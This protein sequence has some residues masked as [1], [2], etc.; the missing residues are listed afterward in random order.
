MRLTPLTVCLL[1]VAPVAGAAE[2][3]FLRDGDRVVFYGDSITD[4][5]WY[6]TLVQTFVLTRHPAW[7]NQFS[8]RGQSGDNAG[9]LKRFERDA[10]VSKPDVVIFAMGY[11]DGGYA[12]FTGASLEKFLSNV[13]ASVRRVR[14]AGPAV[15]I[16]LVSPTP[17]ELAVSSD[18]RWVSREW[19][20][21]HLLM[22]SQGE[23][24]LAARLGVGFTDMTERYGQTLG[25]GRVV[26]GDAFALSRDGVHPQQEGQ[27][28]IA[29]HLLRGLGTDGRLAETVINGAAGTVTQTGRC[30]VSNLSLAD[31]ALTFT[32]TCESLPYPTPEVAR[33][34]R[35]LVQLDDTLNDDRLVVTGLTAPS[36]ALAI[37]GQP[38]AEVAAAALA[39]GINLSQYAGTPMYRQAMEV[40]DAVRAK[41]LLDCGFWR[42]YITTGKADG[43]GAPAAGLDEATRAEVVAAGGRLAAAWEACYALNT[44][45]PHVVK[46]IPLEKTVAKYQSREDADL[47]QAFL[48]VS[49]SPIAV[50]WN[51][52]NVTDGGTLVTLANPNR[53]ARSGTVAWECPDGWAVTPRSAAFTVE[54]GGKV[55]LPF[56]VSRRPDAGFASLPVATARWTWAPE[57]PYPMRRAV[58]LEMRPSWRIPQATTPVAVDGRLDDWGDATAF[59][60]DSLYYMDPAVTGKRALWNG[61]ADLSARLLMKW[62]AQALYLAAVV[63]DAYH[64]Q[65]ANPVM[66]WSQDV[67][68][69]AVFVEEKGQPAGRYEYGFGAYA[70]RDEVVKFTGAPKDGPAVVFRSGVDA[71]AGTCTYEV[72][73]PWNRLAPFVPAAERTFRFTFCVGDADP[74]PGKGFNYLAWTPGISYGKNPA[75]FATVVLGTALKP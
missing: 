63:H 15:R 4:T 58:E 46:L 35:F 70:D 49:A 55:A 40:L 66:M 23:A 41:D 56:T 36:Y 32:R 13:E 37:D 18:S 10:V 50:D 28:F 53:Q 6:P 59:T 5:E 54:A 25:L 11:N 21:Y 1:A 57:W 7:R 44:P 20:P 74:Q 34:F 73:L 68:H 61:P 9:S 51:T 22:Y 71:A 64:I 16:M 39:E 62:D 75:D 42:T 69:I 47:N 19:Y 31:G 8:N 65:N 17:S 30:T 29:Y 67:L 43:A 24:K 72:A 3:F 26:A 33:P 38:V 2:P 60:L 45:K 27:T 12:R 52:L 48:D 14:E